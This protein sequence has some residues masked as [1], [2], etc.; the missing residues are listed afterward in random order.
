MRL[1]IDGQPRQWIP[2]RDF[3]AAFGLPPEFGVGLFEP[4]NYTGLGR[5]DRAGAE[6]NRVRAALLDALPSQ[7]PVRGWLNFLPGYARLFQDQLSAINRQV[8]LKD[9]EIEFAVAGL[10]DVL[11]QVT[12]GLLRINE[13][14]DAK[15]FFHHVYTEWLNNS[16][17]VFAE[18][19]PYDHAGQRWDVQIFAH[20]Y[21]RAG[22]VVRTP[23]ETHYVY[24]PA[25]GCPAEGFMTTLLGEISGRILAAT[26]QS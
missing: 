23:A 22:L 12:Y 4:K 14:P 13:T 3:R 11:H 26:Q 25:L 18:V 16:V 8:G 5:I 15:Q 1:T 10:S 7:M 21:G 17:K 6:L 24:D 2:I 20:A 19:Y 9:V